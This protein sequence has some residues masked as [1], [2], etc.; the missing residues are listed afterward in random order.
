M[1]Q[2]VGRS[3]LKTWVVKDTGKSTIIFTRENSTKKINSYLI[4]AWSVVQPISTNYY[5]VLHSYTL[6]L[7]ISLQSAVTNTEE[8]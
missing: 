6:V 1:S 5:Y 7:A 2:V 8:S 4:P 3:W